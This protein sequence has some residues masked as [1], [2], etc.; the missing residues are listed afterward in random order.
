MERSSKPNAL[1]PAR[2][3][4]RKRIPRHGKFSLVMLIA[5]LGM[6]VI[7][8]F[9]GNAGYVTTEKMN[10]QNAADAAAFSSA[11]WMAR[12]MNA[13]TATN[14]LLGEVTALVV[15]IEG[16]GGPEADLG[17][18]SYPP[19]SKITDKVNRQLA[20][21]AYVKGNPIY[22]TDLVGQIDKPFL[23]FTIKTLISP[24]END[25]KH[26]AFAT[27]YDGKLVLK[28]AATKRL[29]AKFFANFLFLVPPPWGYLSAAGAYV[30][31]GAANVQLVDIGVEFLILHGFEKFVTAGG[32]MKRFKVD[33]LEE[34]LI[35]AIAAHGDFLAG[36]PNKKAKRD[37]NT[38]AAVVNHAVRNSLGHLNGVYHVDGWV[39]PLSKTIPGFANLRLPIE[40]EAPPASKGSRKNEEGWGDDELKF[41][42]PDD[43]L[44]KVFEEIADKKTKIRNRI[45]QLEQQIAFLK[46]LREQVDDLKQRTGVTPEEQQAFDDEKSK[47]STDISQ[48]EERLAKLRADL[49]ELDRQERQM[50]DTV[51]SLDQA[52]SGSGNL[53]AERAHLALDKMDQAEERTTQWVR[54]AYPYVD[55]YR[56]P[57]LRLFAEHLDRCEAAKHYEKWTNRYTL[58]KS[59]KFR[60][61]Y[62]FKKTG[63]NAHGDIGA[64]SLESGV[65][66]L[67]MYLMAE[68]FDP[69]KASPP[70]RPGQVRIAKGTEVWTKDT[71]EGKNMAEDMFTLVAV[72]HRE[73]EPFFSPIIFPVASRNGMTT[74]AQAIYYNSNPQQPAPAAESKVQQK[75]GWDTLNWDPDSSPPE[76]GARASVAPKSEWPWELFTAED[77]FV[78]QARAKL[79][80]QAKLMPVTKRRFQATFEASITELNK[81][82]SE[83]LLIALPLFDKMVTH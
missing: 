13:V 35:P 45:T 2:R 28:K 5:I 27:I 8:G 57:I 46:D 1:A 14:H 17:M 16:L 49:T 77:A 48:L 22:G 12:G 55:A 69:K 70:P 9:V 25:A 78:G 56:A 60:S 4:C 44:A 18:V 6:A 34:T 68:K 51:A 73:I 72:T 64:W 79:N 10:T 20:G 21:L 11:Q 3:Y 42:D 67:Q 62:R 65:E 37:P 29:L 43:Q 58:T 74:F 75:I 24:D 53:S 54:A 26:R 83:N 39:F 7:I 80:W 76:W 33:V 15:M 32:V 40:P 41:E 63:T 31:H 71:V 61:A 50:R 38:E 82:M 47:I 36:K 19:Q 81:P 23:D 66:P 59:W 52:P 30:T